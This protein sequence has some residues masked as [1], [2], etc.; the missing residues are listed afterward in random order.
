MKDY[1]DL[2]FLSCRFQF[3]GSVLAQAIRATF[4]RRE[5]AIPTSTP[6]GLTAEY[7]KD[8]VHAR[9]WAAFIK[10]IG[11]DAPSALEAVVEAVAVFVLPPLHAVSASQA[12]DRTWTPQSGWQQAG[13]S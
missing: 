12:F 7:G 11:A 9:Q 5:T 8:S 4:T 10:R 3:A 2:W 13:K 6:I 1:Y